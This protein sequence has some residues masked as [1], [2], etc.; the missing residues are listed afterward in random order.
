MSFY[1]SSDAFYGVGRY[2][3]ARYGVV[4]PTVLLT[5][6]SATGLTRELHLDG[7]E[8]DIHEIVH[9]VAATGSVGS[10]TLHVVEKLN[11][12]PA[13]TSVGTVVPVVTVFVASVEAYEGIN[14]VQVNVSEV[15]EPVSATFTINA[16]GLDIKS[17][18]RVDI[19]G[20]DVFGEVGTPEV[21]VREYISGVSAT[22]SVSPTKQNL[23]KVPTGVSAQGLVG[24]LTHS[25]LIR[26][27]SVTLIARVGATRENIVDRV[28]GQQL[29]SAIGSL[30]HSNTERL[31]SV[32]MVAS[33]G[34]PSK[35]AVNFDFY[36]VRDLYSAQR[37][38]LIP[39]AA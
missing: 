1:D 36:A 16:A 14:G 33:V 31:V 21:Q 38:I 30:T 24:T 25:N 22:T 10:L 17:I 15:L 7:F 28:V 29:S 27:T 26:V 39:R 20:P 32:G 37:T 2:G 34:I 6:V 12:T 23:K 18:N 13:T 19:F 9:G 8:I 3:S 35:T 11:S 4:T 5:G